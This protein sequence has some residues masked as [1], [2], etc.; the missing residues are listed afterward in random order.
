MFFSFPSETNRPI[1]FSITLLAVNGDV[2]QNPSLCLQSDGF[3]QYD[4]KKGVGGRE[5]G[6]T[7][8]VHFSCSDI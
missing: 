7:L 8:E 2:S 3:Y 5:A 6:T 1:K 4:Q